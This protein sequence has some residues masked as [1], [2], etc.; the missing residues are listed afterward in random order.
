MKKL[1]QG[2]LNFKE[3]IIIYAFPIPTIPKPLFHS[4]HKDSLSKPYVAPLA[5]RSSETRHE[6]SSLN[7]PSL[8]SFH[9]FIPSLH[10]TFPSIY[11]KNKARGGRKDTVIGI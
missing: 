9:E 2:F 6:T 10:K 8:H 7:Y 1:S 11:E 3:R 5:A 4:M